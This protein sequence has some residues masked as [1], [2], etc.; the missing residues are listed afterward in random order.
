MN[1]WHKI[2]RSRV[3]VVIELRANRGELRRESDIVA[4]I[5]VGVF[6]AYSDRPMLVEVV[7]DAKLGRARIR[8]SDARGSD[9]RCT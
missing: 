2:R 3:G 5:L 9:P 4:D 1:V 7:S 8:H 6:N